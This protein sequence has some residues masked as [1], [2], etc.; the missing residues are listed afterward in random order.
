MTEY[1]KMKREINY[2]LR[3]YGGSIGGAVIIP[4]VL[5]L[6]PWRP[7]EETWLSWFQRSGSIT[8]VL[9]LYAEFA[10]VGLYQV[11]APTGYSSEN[12]NSLRE[13]Y[14]RYPFFMSVIV[15]VLTAAGT[16]ISAYGDLIPYFC[17]V[18]RVV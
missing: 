11:I 14:Q 4:A 8:V 5:M 13:H 7:D 6:L 2:W 1:G 10:V 15:L 18:C 12:T 3:L 9:A 16:L 17:L